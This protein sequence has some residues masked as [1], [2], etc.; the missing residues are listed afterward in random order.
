MNDDSLSPT[1]AKGHRERMRTR[2]LAGDEAAL[3]D[4]ALLE[5]LLS[6]SI[7]RRDVKPLAKMLLARFGGIASVLAAGPKDLKRVSGI[8][9]NSVVLLK[10]AARLSRAGGEAN[11]QVALPTKDRAEVG[12]GKL[13]RWP[14]TSMFLR[15]RPMLPNSRNPKGRESTEATDQRRLRSRTAQLA[16]LLTVIQSKPK[17]KKISAQESVEGSGLSARQWE[18]LVRTGAA[19]G[20][21]TPRKQILTALGSLIV[22]MTSF[23]VKRPRSSSAISSPPATRAISSGSRSSTT[24]LPPNGRWLS[25]PGVRGSGKNWPVNT[26]SVRS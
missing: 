20:L 25:P 17:A 10:L 16:S 19:I 2:F 23:L 18:N 14:T 26:A 12:A 21:I 22:N 4:E 11:D 9:E 3:S 13:K 5:L 6:Y 8:K 7:P 24:C 15:P 1:I